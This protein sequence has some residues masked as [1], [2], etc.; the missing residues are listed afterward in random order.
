MS[1]ATPRRS[2][3]IKLTASRPLR[4]APRSS[5]EVVEIVKFAAREKLALVAT[6]A[7]TK[8]GIG[9]APSRYD[10]ALDMTRLTK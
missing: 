9:Y 2:P 6:G 7:R 4:R 5:E 3:H 1:R 10:L 8:L